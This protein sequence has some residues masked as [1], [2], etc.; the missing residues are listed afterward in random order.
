M[1]NRPPSPQIKAGYQSSCSVVNCQGA[2][3]QEDGQSF[4]TKTP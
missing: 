4:A 3:G 2:I 1:F